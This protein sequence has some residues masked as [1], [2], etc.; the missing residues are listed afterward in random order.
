MILHLCTMYRFSHK[1]QHALASPVVY[2]T[3]P[4]QSVTLAQLV[5]GG[6]RFSN[7]PLARHDVPYLAI[8]TVYGQSKGHQRFYPRFAS[9]SLWW[10]AE[11]GTPRK[12]GTWELGL[13]SQAPT[14][15]PAICGEV[16]A[17]QLV[18]HNFA[19]NGSGLAGGEAREACGVTT[20]CEMPTVV[21]L[22]ADVGSVLQT[23]SGARRCRAEG[24]RRAGTAC[25]ERRA[26]RTWGTVR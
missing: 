16:E 13:G 6:R 20:Q 15:A 3:H 22:E 8:S 21:A 25:G 11:E 19:F 12:V 24:L 4:C 2:P 26:S 7:L 14:T 10:R 9:R 1:F 23:S 5:S 18:V 17:R